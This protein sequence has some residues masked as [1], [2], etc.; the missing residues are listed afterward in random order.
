MRTFSCA[1]DA[2][3]ALVQRARQAQ[4]RDGFGN[5]DLLDARQHA[6]HVIAGRGQRLADET[7]DGGDD[8]ALQRRVA[9]DLRVGNDVVGVA[10]A[11]GAVDVGARPRAAWPRLPASPR[12]RRATDEP[13]ASGETVPAPDRGCA[14]RTAD[15][16]RNVWRPRAARHAAPTRT[17]S[18]MAV[19]A[20]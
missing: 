19:L 14:A 2:A 9:E 5:M 10:A 20:L 11:A 13:T 7:R 12:I 6:H 4:Q 17:C 16:R 18:L 8:A 3:A 1:T 15:R